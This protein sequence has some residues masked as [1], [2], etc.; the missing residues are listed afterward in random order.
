MDK[1][2]EA[3]KWALGKMEVAIDRYLVDERFLLE[4]QSSFWK[5]LF[6]KYY[7]N[8]HFKRILKQFSI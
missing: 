6:C 1:Q 4:L 5:R 3:F 7:I 2:I 8:K